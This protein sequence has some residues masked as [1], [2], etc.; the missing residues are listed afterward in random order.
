MVEYILETVVG[1]E[2]GTNILI[3]NLKVLAQYKVDWRV[4]NTLQIKPYIAFKFKLVLRKHL[5]LTS[6]GTFSI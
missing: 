3:C 2:N 6:M 4:L 1:H 5:A